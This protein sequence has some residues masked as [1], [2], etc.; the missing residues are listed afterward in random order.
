MKS[1]HDAG[2][3]LNPFL[4]GLAGW[5]GRLSVFGGVLGFDAHYFLDPEC[6]DQ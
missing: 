4:K 5:G 6:R 2:A 1:V 3:V